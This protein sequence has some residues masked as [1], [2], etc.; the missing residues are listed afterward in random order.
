[1]L[2]NK[3]S[4]RDELMKYLLA[5]PP[6]QNANSSDVYPPSKSSSS[7]LWLME[8]S[9]GDGLIMLTE[10]WLPPKKTLPW[11]RDRSQCL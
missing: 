8:G 2:W 7:L 3:Q 10:I 4:N 9:V 6:T 5:F 1:M 11:Q